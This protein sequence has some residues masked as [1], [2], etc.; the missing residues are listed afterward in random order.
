MSQKKKKLP[1]M[2]K[3]LTPSFK[4]LTLLPMRWVGVEGLLLEVV[5]EAM[6]IEAVLFWKSPLC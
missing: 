2:C 5:V 1:S 4:M 3:E 6:D